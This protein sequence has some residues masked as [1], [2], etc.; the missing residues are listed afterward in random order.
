LY[1]TECSASISFVLKKISDDKALILF[2]TI[3]L[4]KDN[5]H[6]S[7]KRMNLTTKQYHSRI[8]GLISAGLIRKKQGHYYLT[9]LGKVV[10]NTHVV[11]GKALS[12]YWKMKAIESIQS[13]TGLKLACEDMQSLIESLID[14]HQVRD[15]LLKSLPNTM[16]FGNETIV[17]KKGHSTGRELSPSMALQK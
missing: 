14:N 8:L 17:S 3:A 12:Y 7:L 11:I 2:N 1:S 4:I 5:G 13:S 10:Y 15:I 6:I 16:G 9:T